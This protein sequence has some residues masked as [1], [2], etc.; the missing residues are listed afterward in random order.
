MATGLR[1]VVDVP[2]DLAAASSR[3]A[4]R[5]NLIYMKRFMRL[6][7]QKVR[8]QAKNFPAEFPCADY[9]KLRTFADFDDRYTAP[10][11]G[12]QDARHYWQ[13]C[14]SNKYLNKIHIPTWIVN[15]RNDPFL[16]PS[17]FPDLTTHGNLLVQLISPQHGGHCG[18]TTTGRS[19][20]YWTESLVVTLLSSLA[21]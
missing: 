7:G 1:E 10:L 21:L 20:P 11:H 19:E 14:S 15:A 2:G 9:H 8:L 12:F 4:E 5:S 13:C 18:F 16:P 6:M 17:C 3:L